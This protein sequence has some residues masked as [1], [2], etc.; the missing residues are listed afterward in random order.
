MVQLLKPNKYIFNNQKNKL[1]KLKYKPSIG[2]WNIKKVKYK[3]WI[4]IESYLIIIGFGQICLCL[5][6][7]EVSDPS[8]KKYFLDHQLP[9]E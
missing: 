6:L 1:K 7:Y 4:D 3:Y 9:L 2:N 5:G 8:A